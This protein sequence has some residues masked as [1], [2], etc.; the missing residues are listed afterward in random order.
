MKW[1]KQKIFLLFLGLLLLS[2]PLFS[3]ANGPQ[4]FTGRVVRVFDGDSI[5]VM[6]EGRAVEVRL[7]HVDC[8]EKK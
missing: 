8:P 4:S 2:T 5:S 6:R 7:A 1:P 3:Q